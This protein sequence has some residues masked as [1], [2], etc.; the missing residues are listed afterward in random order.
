MNCKKCNKEIDTEDKFCKNCGC[1][2]KKSRDRKFDLGIGEF[3][4]LMLG[5]FIIIIIILLIIALA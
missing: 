4:I 5:L 3:I 1:R 2:V